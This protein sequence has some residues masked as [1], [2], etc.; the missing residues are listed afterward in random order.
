MKRHFPLLA[1]CACAI[2]A[3]SCEARNGEEL[4]LLKK[5]DTSFQG[6]VSSRAAAMQ[7]IGT[8]KEELAGYKAALDKKTRELKAS[9][10]QEAARIGGQVKILEAKLAANRDLYKQEIA[11][12]SLL[13]EGKKKQAAE[14]AR[15]LKDLD[16]VLKS[17]APLNLSTAES[18]GWEARR[19]DIKGKITAIGEEIS[20]LTG[21]IALKRRKLKYL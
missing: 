7:E 10:D 15:A 19:E 8:L 5:D 1:V 2:L 18:Q 13:L 17:K 11:E 3:A 14:L 20:K 9:Y 21:Q 16:D 12:L 6:M 4:E